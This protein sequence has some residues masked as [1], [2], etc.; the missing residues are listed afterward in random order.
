MLKIVLNR[1]HCVGSFILSVYCVSVHCY[2]ASVYFIVLVIH[3]LSFCA[4]VF[5]GGPGHYV[6]APA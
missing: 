3:T 4:K 2:Y 5:E 6:P 1:S